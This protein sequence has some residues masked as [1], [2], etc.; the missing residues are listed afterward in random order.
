MGVRAGDTG[1]E[2]G[3]TDQIGK[4]VVGIETG[5]RVAARDQRNAEAEARER[6]DE[7]G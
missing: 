3:L 2:L 5:D 1:A 4:G 6:A 7:A